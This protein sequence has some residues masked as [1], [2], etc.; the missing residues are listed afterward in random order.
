MGDDTRRVLEFILYSLYRWDSRRH[1]GNPMLVA[2]HVR[3]CTALLPLGGQRRRERWEPGFGP[4]TEG[5][6]SPTACPLDGAIGCTISEGIHSNL[7]RLPKYPFSGCLFRHT[8]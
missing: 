3:W 6:S 2:L 7:M 4:E 5:R 1:G 8:E